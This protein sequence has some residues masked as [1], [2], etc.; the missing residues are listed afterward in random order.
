MEQ[1]QSLLVKSCPLTVYQ[2]KQT[3]PSKVI[4]CNTEDK[5]LRYTDFVKDHPTRGKLLHCAVDRSQPLL[6][7]V[8]QI[9]TVK[10][11]R[12]GR[13]LDRGPTNTIEI[14]IVLICQNLI[15]ASIYL[16]KSVHQFKVFI[17]QFLLEKESEQL[18][19]KYPTFEF[20]SECPAQT[21]CNQYFH[22]L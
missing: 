17:V 11:A 22:F 18:K 8:P 14:K 12:L 16:H 3:C 7:F 9:L 13:T 15:K 4:F 20:Y 2:T 5:H 1:C 19:T 6:Y 21:K 10:L